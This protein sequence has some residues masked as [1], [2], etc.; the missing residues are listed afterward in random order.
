MQIHANGTRLWFDVDGPGLVPHGSEMRQ[1]PTVVLVHGGPGVY[2]HS[3]FKPDFA[4]LAEHAQV[5]YLDLRGHGR[6][7]WGDA[8]DVE[9]RDMRGRP[10]RLLRH[11][12][13]RE[14]DRLRT[15]DGRTDRVAIRRAPSRA[16]GRADRPVGIRTVGR[17]PGW[18]MAFAA[19][20][21]TRSR[22][23]RGA[24]TP[25]RR[26]PTRTGLAS[27]P[28][29]AQPSGRG[30]EAHV[31]NNLELN[32]YG[33]ELMRRLDIV[34]QLSRVDSPTLVSVGELDPVTPVAAAEEIVGALP[35]RRRDARDH[36][37]SRPL[38]VDG[39]PRTLLVGDRRIH[40]Q[41]D[42]TEHVAAYKRPQTLH[43]AAG[44]SRAGCDASRRG[45]RRLDRRPLECAVKRRDDR[46]RIL[47]LRIVPELR[48]PVDRRAGTKLDQRIEDGSSRHRTLKAPGEAQG[49]LPVAHRAVPAVT[50]PD[51]AVNARI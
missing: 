35:K 3:Y 30:A 38:H 21:A 39:R 44:E 26:C 6:S 41:H 45:R 43:V 1:R 31:P 10:P 15:L 7:D 14:A 12:R 19:S 13:D 50:D 33:M 4:R 25:A 8:A 16:C 34:D 18:S 36:R 46:R 24:A 22:R 23:S 47:Q 2:D 20:Q 5:V 42:R 27:S 32:S 28:P 40:P 9:L 48:K 49:T 51:P 29:S 11:A 17:R 37:R